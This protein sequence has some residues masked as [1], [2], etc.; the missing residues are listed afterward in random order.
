VTGDSDRIRF[1]AELQTIR[2]WTILRL[3]KGAS[4]KLPSRGPV[5]VEGTMDGF[6]FKAPLEP[7]GGRGHWLKIG[8]EMLKGTK[9]SPGD[10]L[11]L[12]LEVSRDWPEPEVPEDLKE[13]LEASKKARRTWDATTPGAHWDWVRWIRSTRNPETRKK[14]VEVARSKLESGMRRPCCFNRNLCSETDVSSNGLLL[15][16]QK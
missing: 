2:S 10:S 13:A 8:K 16:T 11:T 6:R 14:R 15:K 3:P 9:A 5:M 7:D 12:D 1:S 4:A